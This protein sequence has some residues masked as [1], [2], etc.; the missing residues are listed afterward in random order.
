MW[1]L[2]CPG[3]SKSQHMGREKKTEIYVHGWRGDMYAGS[4]SYSITQAWNQ[5]FVNWVP[6]HVVRDEPVSNTQVKKWA[7]SPPLLSVRHTT[8]FLQPLQ[9]EVPPTFLVSLW[10]LLYS[11]SVTGYTARLTLMRGWSF[12]K[13]QSESHVP[14]KQV[15]QPLASKKNVTR[16]QSSPCA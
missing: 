7:V 11:V 10:Y 13:M 1:R 12:S 16:K 5:S 4:Q 9:C 8:I 2:K 3:A 15:C 14:L 6:R